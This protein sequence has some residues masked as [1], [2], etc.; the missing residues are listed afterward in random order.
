MMI[1]ATAQPAWG[2]DRGHPIATAVVSALR[3]ARVTLLAA[4][5][6]E[7]AAIAGRALRSIAYLKGL[8]ALTRWS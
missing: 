7:R 4:G 8:R 1:E 3:A 5:V 2:T 6:I